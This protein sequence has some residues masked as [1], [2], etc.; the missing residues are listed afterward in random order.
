MQNAKILFK[1]PMLHCCNPN[2]MCKGRGTRGKRAPNLLLICLQLLLPISDQ[3]LS[4]GDR[5]L[6]DRC[7]ERLGEVRACVRACV[8]TCVRACVR[9]CICGYV[10]GCVCVRACVCTCMRAGVRA[11]VDTCVGVCAC[12]HACT[13]ALGLA[14]MGPQCPCMRIFLVLKLLMCYIWAKCNNLIS[15]TLCAFQS[16][17]GLYD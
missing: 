2:N 5:A 7:R 16:C 8:C 9:A 6:V 4:Q 10:R 15:H 14:P 17:A 1:Q 12:V 3:W 13:C 11:F